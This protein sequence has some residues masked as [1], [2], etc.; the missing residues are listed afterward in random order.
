MAFNCK[1]IWSWMRMRKILR[2]IVLR[3]GKRKMMTKQRK[4][5]RMRATIPLKT[6]IL[7]CPRVG[8]RPGKPNLPTQGRPD[9]MPPDRDRPWEACFES[10]DRFRLEADP[11]KTGSGS[12]KG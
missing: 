5:R 9:I 3:G 12:I 1:M 8:N 11:V 4:K 6:V 2:T 7:T 10:R